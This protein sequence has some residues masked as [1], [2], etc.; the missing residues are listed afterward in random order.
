MNSAQSQSEHHTERSALNHGSS[1]PKILETSA[2][3]LSFL[4]HYW[5][6]VFSLTAAGLISLTLFDKQVIWGAVLGQLTFKM[7]ENK[8]IQRK[9]ILTYPLGL[10]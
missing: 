3:D 8:V 10:L 2:P 1:D 6:K 5:V 4:R 9:E 7:S